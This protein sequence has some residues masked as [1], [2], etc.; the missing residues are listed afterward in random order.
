MK[1][2]RPSSYFGINDLA[3]LP[4]LFIRSRW[5]T[6]EST[7][8]ILPHWNWEVVKANN[9]C[10]CTQVSTV[11]NFYKWQK[12]GSSE[13]KTKHATKPLSLNVD[14]CEI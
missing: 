9:S 14:G 10:L 7:L 4:L 6:K 1:V 12:H 5:N 2:G 13:K 11:L 8:H 3:G